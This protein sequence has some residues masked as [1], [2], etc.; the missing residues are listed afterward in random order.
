MLGV[1][2]AHDCPKEESFYSFLRRLPEEQG[3]KLQFWM[4]AWELYGFV[5]QVGGG[6]GVELGWRQGNA[7]ALPA[8]LHPPHRLLSLAPALPCPPPRP[9]PPCPAPPRH[10]MPDLRASYKTTALST[11]V[12]F[13]AP[14]LPCPALPCPALPWPCPG[15]ALAL[16]CRTCK[17]ATTPR[18][19]GCSGSSSSGSDDGSPG[20]RTVRVGAR[21]QAPRPAHF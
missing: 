11:P 10:A 3:V 1:L 12:P 17:P 13:P 9:A 6:G 2:G 7:P 21:N 16:P 14:A 18:C 8:F 4:S 5:R 20:G 15:P 19:A